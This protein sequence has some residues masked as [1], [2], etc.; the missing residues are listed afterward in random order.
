MLVKYISRSTQVFYLARLRAHQRGSHV[1]E[2]GDLLA[3]LIVED[4]GGYA[5]AISVIPPAPRVNR[6][7]E[8]RK[9]YSISYLLSFGGL[10][11]RRG[12]APG[13]TKPFFSTETAS[14]ILARLEESLPRAEPLAWPARVVM[15]SAVNRVL[16]ASAAIVYK[17]KSEPAVGWRSLVAAVAFEVLE[18]KKVHPLHLLAGALQDES[19][20][21]VQI[22]LGAGITREKALGALRKSRS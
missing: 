22:F 18:R 5:K 9:S 2:I 3:A 14:S 16:A 8:G 11:R 15:D 19:N 12:P 4:Q 10:L 13:P 7:H 1:I 6:R 20:S 21:E 17:P